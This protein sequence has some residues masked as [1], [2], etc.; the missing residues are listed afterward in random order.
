M[1]LAATSFSLHFLAVRK[2]EVEYFKDT[3]FKVYMG[4]ILLFLVIFFTD[5]Y[6]INFFKDGSFEHGFRDSLFTAVSLLTTTGFT[7]VD[8]ESWSFTSQT[9]IFILFF[10]GGCAGSTTGG[11]KIIRTLLVMKFLSREVKKLIH[12]KG[13]FHIKIAD[14]KVSEEVVSNTIG[15]YL[16]YIFIFVFASI[17]FAFFG[18][19][20]ITSLSVSASAIGNIGPGLG[21]IGP[22]SNW[23]NLP[24]IAKLLATFLM[25]LGRLEIFTVVLLFSGSFIKK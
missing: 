23:N 22:S 1:I 25:L 3:E 13:I 16:F 5:N 7:T 12:P 17:M 18:S 19:D 8:Y 10:I 21:E 4:L 24:D 14:K 20:F 11:I 15:F 6:F 9:M 2:G